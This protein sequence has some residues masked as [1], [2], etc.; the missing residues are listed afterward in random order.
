[1]ETQIEN[2]IDRPIG[3][4]I[5]DAEQTNAATSIPVPYVDDD[6]LIRA[7]EVAVERF[8]QSRDQILPMARGLAAAKRMYP[9]KQAFGAW[10]K[11][12][13]YS[14]IDKQNRSALLNIGKA[15]GEREV[16][17]AEFL[18]DTQLV[19]PQLIWAEIRKKVQPTP[20]VDPTYY[21]N[22]SEDV[23]AAAGERS[24]ETKANGPAASLE[25]AADAEPVDPW[26]TGERFDLVVLKPDERDLRHLRSDHADPDWLRTCLPLRHVLE[27][28]VAAVVDTTIRDLPVIT[29][30]LLPLCGFTPGIRPRVLMVRQPQAPEVTDARVL[31]AIERGVEFSAPKGWLD[32]ADPVEIAERLYGDV[33]RSL[34]VFGSTRTSG[35][36]CR[37]WRKQPSVR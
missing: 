2:A 18:R 7:G 24:T 29:D 15:L 26:T 28:D 5:I 10:L 35:W 11:G 23:P 19:S 9:A 12:S 1:V 32:D 30:V 4:T 3:T 31:V 25:P 17:V 37:T 13:A 6:R 8:K 21:D 27:D 16:V 22:R 14:K 20:T 33:S 34:L 36:R